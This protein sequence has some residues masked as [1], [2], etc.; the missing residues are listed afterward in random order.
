MACRFR[1]V[2]KA[3]LSIPEEAT[4][5]TRQGQIGSNDVQV[6]SEESRRLGCVANVGS[7]R[8]RR[9]AIEEAAFTEEHAL[10]W[11]AEQALPYK[12]HA[13][14]PKTTRQES[15]CKYCLKMR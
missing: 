11:T 7:S 15:L 3:M 1:N 10:V 8:A 9:A 12:D 2:K 6:E 13:P 14:S 5:R 4:R